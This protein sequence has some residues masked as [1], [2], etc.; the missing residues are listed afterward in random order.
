[1]QSDNFFLCQELLD[2]GGGQESPD[3]TR[4][5]KKLIQLH[6]ITNWA[7]CELPL[8]GIRLKT[9]GRAPGTPLKMGIFHYFTM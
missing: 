1:M 8:R 9:P 6:D 7:Y 2:I 4:G 5:G 3:N